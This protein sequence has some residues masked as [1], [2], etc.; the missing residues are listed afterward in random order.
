MH[1]RHLSPYRLKM[2]S[3]LL[4]ANNISYGNNCT[5]CPMAK[6][7]KLLFLL[8]SISTHVATDLLHCD[9][10][11]PHKIPTHS[12][13]C[14]FLTIVDDFI[15]YTNQLLILFKLSFMSMSKPSKLTMFLNSY[16]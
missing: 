1:L 3:S 14:F 16:P 11:G 6:Q 7:T 2:V 4:P 8:S 12:G 15:G 5:V 10:W 13:A 9:I